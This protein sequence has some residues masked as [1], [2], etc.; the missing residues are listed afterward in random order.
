MFKKALVLLLISFIPYLAYTQEV[1]AAQFAVEIQAKQM[2]KKAEILANYFAQY[3]SPLQYHAQDFI[4]ASQEY[5]VDWKLVP[6]IAGTE[7]TFGKFIPGGYNAW[8][9][10]VYGTQAIYF[11]SWRE[12]I[13]TVT[14][15]LKENYINKG[16]T[17]PYAMNRVYAAS[18]AWGGHVAYFMNDLDRY[19]LEYESKNTSLVSGLMVKSAGSSAQL[20]L[21]DL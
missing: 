14:K 2:D 4:D 15:G 16:L 19:A 11:N 9:W 13:F 8:G 12:A 6:A 5:G 17:N 18:P 3:G 20:A 21:A 10:G 1:Q 7:S